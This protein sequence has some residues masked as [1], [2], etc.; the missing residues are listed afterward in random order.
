MTKKKL[1]IKNALLVDPKNEV[2]FIGSLLV[3][4]GIIQEIFNKPSPNYD[5]SDCKII[6]CKKNVLSPGL[7]DMWVFAGEP[8]YEHIE[9]IEDISNAAKASGITSIACRPDTNPIIDE[10]ELVQYII[11]KSEDKSQINILPI[12]ALTKKHEGKNM[13]EI[14]L[15]KEVGAVGFSD[16]YN[17]INNTNILKNVF[18]Y[19]SNFNAQ[20]MQLPVSDLDKFGVMNESEISM[21]LGLP[22]IAKIS[23]TIAL[24]REL[25]IAH[26]TKVKYHSMCISTSESYDV[27]NKFKDMNDKITCGV[28]VNNLKLNENDVAAYRTF[29]KVK[30][31]LRSENDRSYILENLNNDTIDII[32][33][34]HEPQGT[35]SKRLPFEEAAYGAVGIETLLAASLSLYHEGYISLSKLMKKMSYNP[36]KI[37]NLENTGSLE[38]GKK[39]DLILVDLDQPWVCDA[40]KLITKCK[41]TTFENQ[42]MQGRVLLTIVNGNIIHNLVDQ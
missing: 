19:A 5:I 17:E 3:E 18:T 26:H 12:A 37:L 40:D 9:T 27:V 8:G 21:R 34:N 20:I 30:P 35:E 13:T 39:A 15:L 7:I 14:G 2:E 36:A 24:E 25:R 32:T 6:D 10:A 28:S 31:P 23:E 11:R 29:F 16:A 41:N 1:L 4:K 33:S 22:G 42:K 38:V